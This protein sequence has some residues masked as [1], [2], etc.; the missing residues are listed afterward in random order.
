M[1]FA[2]ALDTTPSYLMGWDD[3]DGKGGGKNDVSEENV[4]VYHCNGQTRRVRLSKENMEMLTKM[5]DIF[6]QSE[7]NKMRVVAQSPIPAPPKLKDD[8]VRHT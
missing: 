8:T 5:I 4:V 3:A 2:K 1:K 7:E 6:K